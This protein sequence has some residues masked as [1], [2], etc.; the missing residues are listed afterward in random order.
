MVDLNNLL[1]KQDVIERA[2]SRTVDRALQFAPDFA[3]GAPGVLVLVAVE[4]YEIDDYVDVLVRLVEV[5]LD[6]SRDLTGGL[7][8]VR[9]SDTPARIQKNFN[10]EMQANQRV[11]VLLEANTELPP[12]VAVATDCILHLPAIGAKDFQAACKEALGIKMTLAQARK[13][14]GY[15]PELLRAALRKGRPIGEALNKIQQHVIDPPQRNI[16]DVCL[17]EMHGYGEAKIWGLQLAEDLRAW[18]SGKIGWAD[19]D[20]GILLS[21]PPGVG[22]TIFAQALA[23]QC[24]VNLTATSYA[25]WQAQGTGHLGDCLKAMRKTFADARSRA[26]TILFVDELDSVGD[27]SS[28]SG[29]SA[30]YSTQVVNAFLELLDGLGDRDGVVVVG[31]TNDPSRIDRAILRAG[32]LDKHVV[33]P[34][35]TPEDRLAILQQLSGMPFERSAFERLV[36]A[37]NGMSGADLTKVVRDA[38]RNARTHGRILTADDLESALPPLVE[39]PPDFLTRVAVH[40]TG[41]TLVGIELGCGRF[42]ETVVSRFLPARAASHHCGVA[43]FEFSPFEL[44]DRKFYLDQIAVM[45]AGAAAEELWLESFADGCT[46]DF[47]MATRLATT[48]HAAMGMGATLC[49]SDVETD[50]DLEVLRRT[51]P[52]LRC[53]IDAALNEQF[54]RAK[55]I[56]TEK[57]AVGDLVIEELM[58]KNRVTPT[59]FREL[60]KAASV[61]DRSLPQLSVVE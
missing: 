45:L 32:R 42:L 1:G 56:L 10:R 24:K 57:R 17:S 44:R 51:D 12:L 2:L 20:R 26:P 15:P 13:A 55:T 43:S 33:I 7:V 21:G 5:G 54:Q 8:I 34:T 16:G 30:S 27:R 37:T 58:E 41:H 47:Q 22:K 50:E 52:K 28:F 18:A 40:E 36:L 19:V 14:I 49:H 11:V 4:G 60:A 48:I 39:M 46:T 6:R 53:D 3:E 29:Q 35:P 25:Q 23:N 61:S 38:R 31:A 59:R 9:A